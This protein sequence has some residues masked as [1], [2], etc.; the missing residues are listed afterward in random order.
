MDKG[1]EKGSC[2]IVEVKR[3]RNGEWA[4]IGPILVGATDSTK[5]RRET[6]ELGEDAYSVRVG[7]EESEVSFLKRIS[8]WGRSKRTGQYVELKKEEFVRLT[9]GETVELPLP[10]RT[11]EYDRY[12]LEVDGFYVTLQQIVMAESDVVP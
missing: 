11:K 5:A 6:I 12:R 7:E 1:W 4:R 2:P 3:S 10:K 8:V 9:Y